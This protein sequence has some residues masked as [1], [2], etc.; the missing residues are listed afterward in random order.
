MKI[1][2]RALPFVLLSGCAA[3]STP[4]PTNLQT[5]CSADT[6]FRAGYQSRAYYGV[7]PKETE[8][9]FL[10]GLEKGRGYRPNPPQA[11]PYYERMSQLEKQI[12][13]SNSDADREG[14]RVQLR[15]AEWWAIHIAN[16]SCS[17]AS[18]GSGVP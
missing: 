18:G 13:A 4:D 8:G 9:A 5:Y 17:Y 11:L 2:L 1:G 15:D 14:L 6:G 3:F 16:C 10:A 12:V 7:C